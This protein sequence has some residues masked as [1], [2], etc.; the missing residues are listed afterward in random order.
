M[1][2]V[3]ASIGSALFSFL[4]PG[5]VAGLA[6]WWITHWRVQESASTATSI[7]GAALLLASAAALIE[8]FAQFVLRGQ[9]TPAPIAPTARLVVSGLY[10]YVRNPMYLAVL[11]L[12]F[13]QVLLFADAALLAY[14]AAVFVVFQLFVV[15]YEEPRLRQRFPESY[16]AYFQA[17]PRWRPRLT[18]WRAP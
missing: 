16:A 18:P 9:G 11:G 12:I 13:A 10:R 5:T 15:F 2:R 6:P 14:G 3:E 7:A 1:G 17:V 4:A 8:C